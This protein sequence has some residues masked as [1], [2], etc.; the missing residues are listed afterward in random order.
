MRSFLISLAS[1]VSLAS[2]FTVLRHTPSAPPTLLRDT[3]VS[4]FDKSGSGDDGANDQQVATLPN[5]SDKAPLE[6]TWDNVEMVLDEMRPYLIQDGGNVII[7][8][9]D[10]P[11]VLLE[12]QGA[13]GTCPSSTVRI[14]TKLSRPL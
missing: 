9:I 5:M 6:L 12:L 2:A 8:D 4:P 3:I 10:G 7:A 13:C 11:V 14:D 1:A